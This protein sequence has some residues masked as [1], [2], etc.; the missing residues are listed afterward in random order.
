MAFSATVLYDRPPSVFRRA[1]AEEAH[2]LF[3][4][5]HATA[6]VPDVIGR[7]IPP[8][9]GGTILTELVDAASSRGSAR[10][11]Q[12][13]ASTSSLSGMAHKRSSSRATRW[14]RRGDSA[15]ITE[16]TK[17]IQQVL[18]RRDRPAL[19]ISATSWTADE[20]FSILVDAI[21]KYDAAAAVADTSRTDA[22]LPNLLILVTGKGP[23]RAE[24]ERKI[25][26]LPLTA[27]AVRT[28]WLE[29]ADYPRLLGCG[30]MGVCL[31]TSSSGLDLPMKVVDMFGAGMPVA[32]VAFSCL[33]ELLRD[34]ENGR[35]FR[36]SDELATQLQEMLR[37]FP[38]EPAAGRLHELGA[39]VAKFQAV[40]WQDNWDANARQFF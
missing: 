14:V 27:V 40:R 29:A 38:G 3:T 9:A 23:M 30:D 25:A 13:Q 39:G 34:G 2:T 10:D 21:V 7:G 35:V 20:D 5:L 36:S 32:A 24:Y 22:R 8:S 33:G 26:A 16:N 6:A 1:T 28:L 18:W 19:L 12:S 4:R 15:K 17:T 11:R 31:H 37:G